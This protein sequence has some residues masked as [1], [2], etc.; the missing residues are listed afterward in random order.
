MGASTREDINS[1]STKYFNALH[2]LGKCILY[3]ITRLW[4]YE[5]MVFRLTKVA[6]IQKRALIDLHKF[7]TNIIQERREFMKDKVIE[8]SDDNYYGKKNRMAMLDLL[9]EQ[10]KKGKI[11]EEGIREEVDTFMFEVSK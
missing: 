11:D 7:T 1:V 3:R 5:N 2:V 4:T 9:L 8:L 6:K 10:E